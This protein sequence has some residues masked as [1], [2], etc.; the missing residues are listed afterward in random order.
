MNRRPGLADLD[1]RRRLAIAVMVAVGLVVAG[2]LPA[3]VGASRPPVSAPPA[4]VTPS[5]TP[6]GPT[7]FPSFVPPTATPMPTFLTYTVVAGDNL[8]S[9]SHLFQTTGRSIAFWNRT[10]YP[11]LDP[12][13]SS[14]APNRLKVGWTLVL[15]PGV[16]FDEETL[17]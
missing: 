9:I 17:P 4:A 13:S 1:R 5:P 3:S 16:V 8:T 7:P 12:E 14:Y 2:C 6:S 10:R 15:I 11:T